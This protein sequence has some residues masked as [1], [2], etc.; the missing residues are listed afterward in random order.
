MNNDTLCGSISRLIR[1]SSRYR[2]KVDNILVGGTPDEPRHEPTACPSA[3]PGRRS[4][5]RA[6]VIANQDK[7]FSLQRPTRGTPV[8]TKV[9]SSQQI[10]IRLTHQGRPGRHRLFRVPRRVS[11]GRH[12]A[13]CARCETHFAK[14]DPDQRITVQQSRLITDCAEI[15]QADTTAVRRSPDPAPGVRHA[16]PAGRDRRPTTASS[17]RA[18]AARQQPGQRLPSGVQRRLP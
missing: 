14:V 15:H 16:G 1:V 5:C 11:P 6:D 9:T 10:G 7:A 3:G 4:G 8:N 18:A 12:G 2:S 17:G 13:G